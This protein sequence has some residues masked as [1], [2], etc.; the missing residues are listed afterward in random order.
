MNRSASGRR[1]RRLAGL[2]LAAALALTACG[3][4]EN[5]PSGGGRGDAQSLGIR[6]AT[7]TIQASGSSAQVNAMDEW[8]KTYQGACP[9]ATINYQSVGSGAGI[10]QFV[11]GSTSFAGSDSALKPAE[12]TRAAARCKTGKAINL[13]MVIGP[14][15]VAYNL[16]GVETL[17]LRPA[18]IADIFSGKITRWNDP[19]IRKDNAGT[20]LPATGIQAFHR[21]DSSGT[22]ENFTKFLSAAG[23]PT[24]TYGAGKEWKAPGGQGA[25]GSE[26]VA[27]AVKQTP[28]AVSYMEL[29]FADN[30]NLPTAR[31]ANGSGAF[32]ELTGESAGKAVA[33]ASV[34]G[35]GNDLP[36]TID[37]TTKAADAYPLV[38]VTY[39]ITCE[40]GLPAESRAVVTSFLSYTASEK[41]QQQLAELGYAPLPAGIR[42]KVQSAVG[43]IS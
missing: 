31:V 39:E 33:A 35:T 23:G 40:K 14:I 38:L 8:S 1:A 2:S 29:S 36:L 30:A 41:G 24:W 32:V 20:T 22:T 12:A 6:C 7:G 43:A 37:Y 13:P 28:G 10:E 9:G 5:A 18:V 3:S 25:K 21:S 17:N 15:A 4:D 26:G 42:T 34:A 11:Q 19:E 27:A 16:P